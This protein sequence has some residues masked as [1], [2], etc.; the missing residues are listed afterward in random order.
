MFEA[1][2]KNR[3]ISSLSIHRTDFMML[4]IV[5][6]NVYIETSRSTHNKYFQ[7]RNFTSSLSNLKER[8]LLDLK[9]K[10]TDSADEKVE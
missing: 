6:M 4:N 5:D 7:T 10:N 9:K 3:I 2:N 8:N 1:W